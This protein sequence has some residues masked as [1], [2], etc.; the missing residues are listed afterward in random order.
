MAIQV[1]EDVKRMIESEGVDYRICTAC[2]GPAL[3][4]VTV[5]KPKDTD[6]RIPLGDRTL[7]VSRVQARYVDRVTMDMLYDQDEIDSCPAFS[8][9]RHRTEGGNGI[10]SIRFPP[11]M[12]GTLVAFY[13]RA[14]ENYFDGGIRSI[15]KG[16]TAYAAEYIADVLG[17]DILEI[18]QAHPYPDS[19]EGCVEEAKVDWKED[20]RPEIV[21]APA[22]LSGYP[23]IFLCY[24]NYCGT[25]P[26]AVMTFLE[27]YD[28]KGTRIHPLCTNE[29]SGMGSSV[30]D[31][32]RGAPGAVVGE[33]LSVRGGK[34]QESKEEIVSWAKSLVQGV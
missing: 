29:G 1:D 25:V 3:V 34:V 19:Y 26:M 6:I 22:D 8:T 17:A 12:S 30:K 10:F 7:Y 28:L 15:P 16:N 33:G 32:V 24:P 11:L 2:T 14:G 21:G 9:Y 27:R 18:R 23:D 5:K 13:S 31:V 4:P 20:R